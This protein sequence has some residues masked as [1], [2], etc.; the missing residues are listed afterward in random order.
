MDIMDTIPIAVAQ[1]AITIGET[2]KNLSAGRQAIERAA[3]SGAVLVQLPELWLTGYDLKNCEIHS[4][5]VP[6]FCDHMQTLADRYQVVIGGS[7]IT[8]HG[9][10]YY[11][12][13]LLFIPGQSVPAQYDKTHL[14]RLLEEDVFFTPGDH[15]TVVDLKWG[16][17]GLAI[18]YDV[19][20]PE[21]IRAYADRGIDCL[22]VAAQWG[23]QRTE[24]W[25]TLLRA[26]AIENQ[27]FVI[28]ANGFGSIHEKQLAGYSVVLD[29]W[30][31]TLAEAGPTDPALLTARLDLSD[32][33][34]VRR[35]VPSRE[36]QRRELYK[37]W[38]D[39]TN[40]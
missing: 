29:P 36:D 17:I 38:S 20:F 12:S 8:S 32:I 5:A 24:H 33:P 23:A 6:Q 40:K 19:R 2:E 14:F 35:A 25:R 21:L 15:L 27:I 3:G 7:T 16:R 28:A 39:Q 10:K 30:G 18:C 31:N 34:R 1:F 11:N 13:Y 22:L 37:H 4:R 26:R 9:G